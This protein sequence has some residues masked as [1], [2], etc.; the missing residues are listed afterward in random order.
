M[1]AVVNS[2]IY[3]CIGSYI[4]MKNSTILTVKD[5]EVDS[6]YPYESSTELSKCS[7][8]KMTILIKYESANDKNRPIK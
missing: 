2:K 6:S 5:D 7:F 4:F 3:T 1:I 8:K